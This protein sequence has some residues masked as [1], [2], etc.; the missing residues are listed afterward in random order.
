MKESILPRMQTNTHDTALSS[1][2]THLHN[3]KM[4]IVLGEPGEGKTITLLD[5]CTQNNVPSYYFRC[6]PNTKMDS[7]LVF[8]AKAIGIRVVAD[9]DQLQAK[10]QDHLQKNP[11]Y[12]FA[13]DE[14]EY[15][16]SGNCKKLDVLRQIFDDTDVS[17]V[18]CGT[19]ELKDVIT[20]ENK[21][22]KRKNH[23]RSQLYRRLRKVE[24]E[25]IDEQEIYDYLH[26][27]EKEYA[28]IFHP[29]VK[30]R[31]VT[32][33]RDRLDGGLG[34]FIEIIE[35]LFSKVRPEWEAIS[36]QII[37]DTGRILQTHAEYIQSFTGIKP[38]KHIVDETTGEVQSE[39]SG[40]VQELPE[41]DYVDVS[42]L[43]PVTIDNAIYNDSLRHKM[44][45]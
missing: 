5:F 29:Q 31:L 16:I 19:Y 7:L 33:C 25:M 43:E 2:I 6:S 44:I 18:I 42:K 27:L 39:S 35:L 9:N 4:V 20:G 34:N 10:I 24:F 30:S 22:G 41:Y 21:R 8:M 37:R 32:H 23:N 40:Y 17:M 13:F 3:R 38:E 1:I 45:K 26:L 12:C 28:V 14:A 15:L 11:K 36:Y